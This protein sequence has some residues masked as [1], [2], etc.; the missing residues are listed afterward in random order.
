MEK[1]LKTVLLEE[2]QKINLKDLYQWTFP[3]E[4]PINMP[5][6][7]SDYEKNIYLKENLYKQ[8]QKNETNGDNENFLKLSYWIVKKWGNL[9]L[10]ENK[11]NNAKIR[12]FIHKI[13][14]LNNR[15]LKSEFETISS[16]S[17][18]AS[19]Y[20]PQNFAIYDSRAIYSLNW[21]IFKHNLETK[22][23]PQPSGRNPSIVEYDQKTIFNLSKRKIEYYKDQ[24]A[25]FEYCNLLKNTIALSSNNIKIYQIEMFLFSMAAP[26]IVDDIKKSL[27][28]II[29]T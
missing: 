29:K 20:S 9:N 6:N 21:I 18:I 2:Y 27:S 25:Y 3:Q 16:L 7:L 11:K 14:S 22:F 24:I 1:D 4:P 26:K 12:N 15:L 19:F 13:K 28:L 17:K 8:L 10:Q 23:F 5:K